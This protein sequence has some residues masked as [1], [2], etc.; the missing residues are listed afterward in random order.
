MI[1]NTERLFLRELD[2]SDENDIFEMDS[3]PDVHR[4]IDNNPVKSITQTREFIEAI[5]NQ[6]KESGVAR[7]AVVCKETHECLGWAGLEFFKTP[8]NNHVNFYELGYRFKKKHWGK[9]YATESS[10]AIIGY[11]FEQLNINTI[12]AITYP[13]HTDSQRVLN[14]LGFKHANAFNYGRDLMYWFELKRC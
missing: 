14:K 13:T 4:F 2:F 10:K 7:M 3:D 11:G 12:F 9:G 5:Q 8:V 1:L 6:Y